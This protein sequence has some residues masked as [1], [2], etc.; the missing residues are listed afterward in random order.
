MIK[1]P[2]QRAAI[3]VK[4][5]TTHCVLPPVSMPLAATLFAVELVAAAEDVDDDEEAGATAAFAGPMVPPSTGRVIVGG[6][7]TIA[8]AAA[9][10]ATVWVDLWEP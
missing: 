1:P 6:L 8:A 7:D 10:S 3:P 9:N 4:A 2:T 5:N